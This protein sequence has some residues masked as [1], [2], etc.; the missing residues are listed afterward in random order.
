MNYNDKEIPLNDYD[1]KFILKIIKSYLKFPFFIIHELCHIVLNLIFGINFIITSLVF[2]KYRKY[3]GDEKQY[4]LLY[5]M[6]I[7][8][9]GDRDIFLAISCISPTIV[10]WLIILSSIFTFMYEINIWSFFVYVY[11]LYCYD[12]ATCSEEDLNTFKNCISDIKTKSKNKS[13][14]E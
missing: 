7:E 10:W 13:I 9:D 5:E 2:L 12:V 6:V 4:I 3:E 1:F 14:N 8:T 11:S